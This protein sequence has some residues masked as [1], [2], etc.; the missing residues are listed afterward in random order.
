MLTLKCFRGDQFDGVLLAIFCGPE[1]LHL[2]LYYWV[3]FVIS[4]SCS[5]VHRGKH[6]AVPIIVTD[7]RI[8]QLN[9]G[10]L[11]TELCCLSTYN[12]WSFH[13]CLGTKLV[14]WNFTMLEI[15][16][17]YSFPCSSNQCGH[18]RGAIKRQK[19]VFFG[20]FPKGGGGGLVDSKISLTEKTQIFL[21]FLLKGGGSHPIQ[22]G[23]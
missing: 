20:H 6:E 1:V 13:I 3:L 9:T 15:C 14:A 21:D 18:I 7:I 19:L 2:N 5:C 17:L 8:S 12:V 10:Y 11:P 4:C 16:R 23:F 22:K